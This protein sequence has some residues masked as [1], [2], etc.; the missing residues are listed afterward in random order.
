VGLAHRAV[1]RE[2]AAYLDRRREVI[3]EAVG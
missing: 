3:A 1:A 2:A